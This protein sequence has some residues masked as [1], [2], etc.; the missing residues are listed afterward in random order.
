VS[1]PAHGRPIIEGKENTM[2][3]SERR[4][5]PRFRIEQMVEVSFNREE[6]IAAEGIDLS[7]TGLQCETATELQTGDEMFLMLGLGKESIG[8]EGIVMHVRKIASRF[9][10]GIE[11]TGMTEESTSTLKAFLKT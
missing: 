3:N 10:I 6:F 11:F 8:C 7:L 4:K 2:S 9:R 1:G 5:T